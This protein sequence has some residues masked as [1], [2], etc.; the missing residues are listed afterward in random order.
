MGVCNTFRLH[1][2]VMLTPICIHLICIPRGANL[3]LYLSRNRVV[4]SVGTV[5]LTNLLA[6]HAC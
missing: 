1:N 6:Y 4:G 5:A 3:I 2:C